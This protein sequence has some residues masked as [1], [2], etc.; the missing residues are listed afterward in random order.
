MEKWVK[1]LSAQN[2]FGVSGVN[3]VAAESNTIEVTGQIVQTPYCPCGVM[4]VSGSPDIQI[5]R[6]TLSVIPCFWCKCPLWSTSEPGSRGGYQRTFRLKLGVNDTISS[7]IWM[8]GLPDT[9]MTSQEQ[10]G[11]ILCFFPVVFMCLKKW[12]AFTS[13]VLD[14]AL[15]LFTPETPK[16]FMD[17]NTLPN[18]P[19]AVLSRQSYP[20][21][22]FGWTIPLRLH[23]HVCVR[24]CMFLPSEVCLG[25]DPF[26][27]FWEAIMVSKSGNHRA[28][29]T[30]KQRMSRDWSHIHPHTPTYTQSLTHPRPNPNPK[31]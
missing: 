9:W 11:G 7:R 17:S 28:W 16:C 14:S 26:T 5:R 13:V 15:T 19:S 31:P 20:I 8:S 10:Y 24:E 4:Q 22:I 1:C 12:S 18:P 23:V 25:L 6:K 2:T 29:E 21:L 3:S 30:K 27:S